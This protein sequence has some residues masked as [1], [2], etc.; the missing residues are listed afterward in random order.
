MV[1][2]HA[3]CLPIRVRGNEDPCELKR[4]LE[5]RRRAAAEFLRNEVGE[6]ADA[7][8]GGDSAPELGARVEYRSDLR[9]LEN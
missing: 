3:D 5:I 7:E 6:V 8:H 2:Q 4:G 1:L 9:R